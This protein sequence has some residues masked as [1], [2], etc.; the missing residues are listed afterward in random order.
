MHLENAYA[1]E[2]TI[3]YNKATAGKASDNLATDRKS[4]F[5]NTTKRNE[6]SKSYLNKL[7]LI[8]RV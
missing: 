6:E 4:L 2:S 1:Q 8:Y 3:S 5:A 7:F